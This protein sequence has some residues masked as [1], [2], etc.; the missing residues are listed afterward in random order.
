[1]EDQYTCDSYLLNTTHRPEQYKL[2]LERLNKAITKSGE[3][4]QSLEEA[5]VLIETKMAETNTILAK[6]S[7]KYPP[8]NLKDMGMFLMKE[9]FNVKNKYVSIVFLFQGGVV[10]CVEDQVIGNIRYFQ[11]QCNVFDL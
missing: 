6:D 4:C 8:N 11:I 1:M 9:K 2:L 3:T 7:I 5:I 10:F